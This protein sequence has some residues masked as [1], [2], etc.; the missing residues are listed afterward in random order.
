MSVWCNGRAGVIGGLVLG[1]GGVA[2][3]APVEALH[4][5]PNADFEAG[6]APWVVYTGKPGTLA[7]G[8]I[9]AASLPALEAAMVQS[10]K[11]AQGSA[12]VVTRTGK[13]D[14]QAVVQCGDARALH[15][16]RV[17][18]QA[19]M[20]ASGASGAVVVLQYREGAP[21]GQLISSSTVKREEATI[22][23]GAALVSSAAHKVCIG[24]MGWGEGT[25]AFDNLTV[26][27]DDVNFARNQLKKPAQVLMGEAASAPATERLH[28]VVAIEAASIEVPIVLDEADKKKA[29]DAAKL[30]KEYEPAREVRAF[31]LGTHEVSRA[32]WNELM[33]YQPW[34][35][36]TRCDESRVDDDTLP[37]T[38][39]SLYDAMLFANQ[40][41]LRE[42][43]KPAYSVREDKVKFD[44]QADG[45]RLPTLAEWR[46]GFGVEA[47]AGALVAGSEAEVC[48]YANVRDQSWVKA[49]AERAK[50]DGVFACDDGHELSAPVGSFKPTATG[51]YD[52][53][54]NVDEWVYQLNDDDAWIEGLAASTWEEGA[55]SGLRSPSVWLGFRLARGAAPPPPEDAEGEDGDEGDEGDAD[56][57]KKKKK[58]DADEAP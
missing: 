15:G 9:E 48:G 34:T 22:A 33:P 35:D 50:S 39:V 19:V 51:V 30:L 42:G 23:V 38:C 24:V 54:G 14:V 55:V 47:K 44:D 16:A 13:S 5:I 17:R 7:E 41:S 8:L 4:E 43:L 6:A 12:A 37:V 1:M 40:A 27:R 32:Q 2:W 53:L 26:T 3:A 49:K 18:V 10:G 45:Y 11:G 52:L 31:E 36:L 58:G 25:V 20:N 28:P 57:K 21:I 46:L 29:K 56:K